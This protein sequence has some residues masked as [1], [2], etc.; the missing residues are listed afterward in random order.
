[1]QDEKKYVWCASKKPR[2]GET[3]HV[4][5]IECLAVIGTPYTAY[6]ECRPAIGI[7]GFDMVSL[8]DVKSFTKCDDCE[9]FLNGKQKYL[10]QRR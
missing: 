7:R 4:F 9:T 1:M 3:A 10:E 6:S 2:K 8:A 5:K